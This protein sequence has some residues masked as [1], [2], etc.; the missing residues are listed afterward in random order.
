MDLL[1]PRW[2]PLF[3]Q[4]KRI[5]DCQS[6]STIT[7][8]LGREG[9]DLANF[10]HLAEQLLPPC[11]GPKMTAYCQ[12]VNLD[13]FCRVNNSAEKQMR[14]VVWLDDRAHTG[15][16]RGERRREHQNPLNTIE[17]CQLLEEPVRTKMLFLD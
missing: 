1:T 8:R 5:Q 17:L 15:S 14:R 3:S 13:N 16:P 12:K 6:Y 10:L 7:S 9:D 11:A 4:P 2:D